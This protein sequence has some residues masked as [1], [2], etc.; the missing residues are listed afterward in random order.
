MRQQIERIHEEFP[1]YGYRRV[2]VELNRRGILTARGGQWYAT[3]V[4]N[5]LARIIG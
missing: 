1:G 2:T 4:R 5:V 3:T